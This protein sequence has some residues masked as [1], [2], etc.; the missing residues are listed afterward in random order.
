MFN[1][2][3]AG[4]NNHT[5]D[6]GFHDPGDQGDP[7]IGI[8]KKTNGQDANEPVL[9]GV[10]QIAPGDPVTW[11]YEVTNT[12]GVAFAKGDVVV[13]DNRGVIPVFDKVLV[14]N[15]NDLLEPNEVWQYKA[16]GIAESVGKPY[17]PGDI[18]ILW[19]IDEDFDGLFSI[20]DYT[21]V[22]AGSAAAG[23]TEWGT[24]YYE[25]LDGVVQ[26]IGKH[27]GSFVI[28]NDLVAYMAHNRDL[29]MGGAQSVVVKAPVMLKYDLRNATQTGQNIVTVVGSIPVP[30]F[31]L[32]ATPPDNIT[33]LSFNPANGQLYS[34][35]Q[36]SDGLV[37]DRLLIVSEKDASVIAD[38][39]DIKNDALGVFSGYGEE[40]EFDHKGN[41][42]VSDN[43]VDQLF[44]VDPETAMI[45]EIVD[46]DQ[47]GGLGVT[48]LKTEGLAWDP[49]ASTM[50]AADD[51]FD[52][53]YNQTL[54][55]GNNVA[56]GSL[57]ELTD[58]EG[59]DFLIPCYWNVGMVSA[60][61]LVDGKVV[62]VS[63]FDPSHY[64]N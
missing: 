52:L 53:F 47:H 29:N 58:V 5:L 10:P 11:T 55:N 27:I 28:D 14:G 24:L 40:L 8:I 39:G 9:P 37:T 62:A 13:T 4:H 59:M 20:D 50:L 45:T 16:S 2:G 34:L 33:G 19:G 46:N 41:L 63:A 61:V 23:L 18:P 17:G 12:G 15:G 30:G 25:D 21:Q 44:K 35:Y 36:K 38:I 7:G 6:F 26:A 54:E 32:G 48:R 49:T 56:I 42:Y 51:Y 60:T 22:G 57:P 1:T 43:R 31:D 64:C 3:G